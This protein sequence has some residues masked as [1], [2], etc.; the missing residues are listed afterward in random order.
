VRNVEVRGSQSAKRIGNLQAQLAGRPS[1][2]P[3][4]AAVCMRNGG[5]KQSAL[6]IRRQNGDWS[7]EVA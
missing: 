7:Q 6:V 1:R 2:P 3:G 5:S 4:W